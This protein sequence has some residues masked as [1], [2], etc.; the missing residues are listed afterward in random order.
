M[1]TVFFLAKLLILSAVISGLIKWSGPLLP[2]L[3]TPLTS[4]V[5]VLTPT[6]VMGLWLGWQWQQRRD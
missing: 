2:I 1:D 3:P 4:V 5:M 6:V